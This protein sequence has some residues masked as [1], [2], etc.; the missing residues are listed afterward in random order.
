MEVL[1]RCDYSAVTG[2]KG[3]TQGQTIYTNTFMGIKGGT[4]MGQTR[5]SKKEES[6]YGRLND[7]G[8]CYAA[9]FQF[10]IRI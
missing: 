3:G 1:Q 9:P 4:N 2:L 5:D 7:Q 6:K 8:G 10:N